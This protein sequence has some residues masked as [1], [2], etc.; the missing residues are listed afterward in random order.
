MNSLKQLEECGQS[1]W[2][3]FVRRSMIEKHEITAMIE[4]DGLKGMTSNPSI[5][6]KGIG[7]SEEYNDRFEAFVTSADKSVNEIY[8]H[9]AVGD[10][11]DAAD[12][13]RP[14]FDATKGVDGYISLE[15]SPYLA[16]DEKGTIAEAHRLRA[17][18]SRDNLMVK[19]P[20]T[21]QCIPAIR[22]L[23][24]D[25]LSINVTLLFSV[26]AYRQV[27]EAYIEGLEARAAAGHDI[28]TIA[29][30]ASFFVSRI[31]VSVDKALDAVAAKGGDKAHL[32]SLRGKVAIANAKRAYQLYLRLFSGPRWDKLEAKGAK[33]QRLLWAS[34]GTKSKTLSDVIYVEELIGKFTVNTM[35]PAT[36]DAFRDH[37]T[38]KPD[39]IEHDLDAAEAT[40]DA[41]E[42]LGIS[43]D[44]IT[45]DLVDDGVKLFAD[46][47][48]SLLGAVARRRRERLE[49]GNTP[50]TITFGAP[51]LEKAVAAETETWRLA[52]NIRRL[53][54]G[55]KTLWTDTDE[56]KWL[57]WLHIVEDELA[58]VEDLKRFADEAVT[59]GGFKHVVLLGMGG[60]S[61]GPA[62]LAETFGHLPGAPKFHML[63]STDPSQIHTLNNALDI[64][65]SL[66]I[67]SSKSGSTLEPNIYKAFFYSRV[68]EEVAKPGSA[69]VAVTDPGS[70]M[71]KV[72]HADG[73][74]ATYFGKP[75]IGGRYSVL[76]KF[77][78]VPAAAIGLDLVALLEAAQ[79]MVRSCGPE[80]PPA[81]NPGIQLGLALGVA[82]RDFARD[83]VTVIASPQIA[84]LGAWLEQLIAES[85][86][87]HGHGLIPID[88]EPLGGPGCYGADRFFAYLT[89]AGAEDHAQ[90][91]AVAA[92]E[93][94]GHPVARIVLPTKAHIA[95][96]FFRWEIA[97]A[98]AGAV[99][100]INPF[101]QPDVEASK[102][103]TRKLTDQ[104]EKTGALPAENPI[105]RHN[106]IALYTDETNAGELGKHNTLEAYLHSHFARAGAGDYV[107]LLAYIEMNAAHIEALQAMR[108]HIRNR[109]R[110]AT[111]LGFG[112]R[113]L[114]STGQA[115]KG[116]PNSGVFL[117]ITCS[118]AN[119][120][121]VPGHNYTFGTVKAAQARGDFA[122]LT[123]R[124]RRAL[125]V[126]LEDVDKGLA[127]LGRLVESALASTAS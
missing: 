109:T 93:A 60:S 8:E 42:P 23:I 4:R 54:A 115:Y 70:H 41:L 79:G 98:I 28:S 89:L 10:I 38:I 55:D 32:D 66:F 86:G 116:G 56:D 95:A 31:D 71:E 106:G 77:G 6:E 36:M 103:E 17:A 101:D 105:F 102:I 58:G 63:D 64:D 104:V 51:A 22:Q 67:V 80:V 1:P 44:K 126:H 120:I 46:S 20:A 81:Q 117:Q 45:S 76:S 37:G 61:L 16:R 111:A 78:L 33:T 5:F 107:G 88:G 72:A 15:V 34:T 57:G 27:A 108:T 112:P 96:E 90:S 30:V 40:L 26:D 110:C 83:K 100:H 13:L 97:T 7:E 73:F 119:D 9:L 39:A 87:K 62:V 14:V 127:E 49:A 75:S 11:Q 114:H 48:D 25:G 29:S 85:T 18:V 47:F 68:S 12:Q 94:A 21:P 121:A 19:V 2:L 92:L 118:D 43:L 3:D 52:G 53:W 50:T 123:E 24:A 122:V 113:F 84:S 125:R 82:A 35:P 124:K 99:I 74:L 59:N 65:T 69:F 91:A